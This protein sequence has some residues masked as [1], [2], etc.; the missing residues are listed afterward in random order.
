MLIVDCEVFKSDWLV[1]WLDTE[2]RKMHHIVNNKEQLEK[3]YQYY[4]DEVMIGYNINHYDKY[5]I[6]GILCDFDP[7]KISDWIINKEQQGW[8]YSRLFNKFPL[9]VFDTMIK[10]KSLKYCEASLGLQIKESSVP[11]NIDRPLTI[12]ELLES[13]EYCKHDVLCTFEVF[14]QSGFQLSPQDEWSSHLSVIKEFNFP[15]SYLAKT[16]AQL[17]CAILG[18]NKTKLPKDEFDII[19][20][21]NLLLGKYEY[22]REWFLNP[23]NHW[24]T[25]QIDGRKQPEK[26]ELKTMIADLEHTFAWGGVHAGIERQIVD[27]ILLNCDFASLYPNIMIEYNLISRCIPNPKRY[28]ELLETRLKLKAQGDSREKC[29]KIALNGS[30]GQMGYESGQMYDKKMA[31][32]VCI[33]GQLIALDLV[34][35]LEKVGIIRMTNTDGVL[36]QVFSE[37]DIKKV[38]YICNEVS[39]R[40]RIG[41]DVERYERY[42]AK[43]VNGY[44]AITD[45]GNVKAKG[46]YVKFLNPLEYSLNIIN[47]AIRDYF[48]YNISARETVM[49]CE[50][51]LDFQIIA[52]AGR[53]YSHC[54][55]DGKILN[56]KTNRVFASKSNSDGGIFKQH[57]SG[58][59]PA[60]VEMT[61]EHCFI[62]NDDVREMSIPNKLDREWYI[63]LA[64]RRI[65]EFVK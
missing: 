31:N 9:I 35:K 60:K 34:E 42:I 47:K 6:Q 29:Y 36:V 25:R 57:K 50:N 44:I 17:G 7:Y 37:E 51:I 16:N 19:N 1:C 58:G 3:F 28:K 43:D 46:S 18:A 38:E 45:K 65:K 59:N 41:I 32:N 10:D 56:E 64:E 22:V 62:I 40:V 15:I 39:K 53:K 49:S 14:L 27:G 12:Q 11:F 20:P 26:N 5:I 54:I 55:K 30:Y 63:E 33:H 21:T 61:P 4:K 52:K 13:I 48:L 24:Y 8:T 23:E 2:T